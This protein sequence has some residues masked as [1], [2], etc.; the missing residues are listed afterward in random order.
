MLDQFGTTFNARS[1]GYFSRLPKN[2]LSGETDAL[3]DDE[4]IE[5]LLLLTNTRT[6]ARRLAKNSFAQYKGLHKLLTEAP[7]QLRDFG[8]NDATI[9]IFD[10]I[11]ESSRRLTAAETK[12][13]P[14]LS[15]TDSLTAYLDIPN[16]SS[17]VPHLAVMLL[18]SRNQVLEEITF[19]ETEEPSSIALSLG[20]R[21]LDVH[22]SAM[23]LAT[24]RPGQSV[25]P[26]ERDVEI[27]KR[28]TKLAAALTISFHEHLIFTRDK[29]YSLKFEVD[30]TSRSDIAKSLHAERGRRP[31][32]SLLRGRS[33]GDAASPV[34]G[35]SD[36][37]MFAT[38]VIPKNASIEDVAEASSANLIKGSHKLRT[39]S[40]SELMALLLSH[41]TGKRSDES[42]DCAIINCGSFATMLS[43]P[44]FRLLDLPGLTAHGVAA[45]K[46]IHAAAIRLF[47]AAVMDQPSLGDLEKLTRYLTAALSR[48]NVEHLRILFLDSD[49]RLRADEAQSRGT[50]NHA[51]V[52]PREVVRRALELKTEFL[53]LVHNHPSGD[54]TPSQDDIVMTRQ[55]E[56]AAA[57]LNLK[58]WDHIIIGNGS[59]FSF[60]KEGL[61]QD[62]PSQRTELYRKHTT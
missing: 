16:R 10:V 44:S 15:D 52:Y 41:V 30:L 55:I 49:G 3:P 1:E 51:P 5:M 7:P 14:L 18:N 36:G 62:V 42:I 13:R 29:S 21:V 45:I 32:M 37:G 59:W 17:G 35:F 20:R 4:L 40:D 54:P 48:E 8:F 58:V 57:F 9:R 53:I 50:V 2:L 34:S 60:R 19:P 46:L 31:G 33:L 26:M 11:H 61:L 47:R 56:D 39:L 27:T 28:V 25:L 22:A 6:N 24:I 23:I 12:L 38:L 43:T